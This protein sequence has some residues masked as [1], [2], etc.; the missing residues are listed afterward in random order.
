MDIKASLNMEEGEI[1]ESINF[2]KQVSK[3]SSKR[4]IQKSFN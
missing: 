2:M 4:T 3:S 1:E